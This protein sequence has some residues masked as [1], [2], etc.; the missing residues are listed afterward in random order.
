MRIAWAKRVTKNRPNITCTPI[1]ENTMQDNSSL[2]SNIHISTLHKTIQDM[3]DNHLP[4]NTTKTKILQKQ[5]LCNTYFQDNTTREVRPNDFDIPD[6][7]VTKTND[8]IWIHCTKNI[9]IL[10]NKLQK[11]CFTKIPIM[12]NNITDYELQ[13]EHS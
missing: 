1:I 6:I 4:R 5:E 13:G 11:E 10:L 8:R 9:T 3:C 2:N 7:I 12:I